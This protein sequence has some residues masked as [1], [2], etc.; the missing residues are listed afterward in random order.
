MF[1]PGISGNPRGRPKGS[2]GGRVEARIHETFELVKASV[3]QELANG[4]AGVQSGNRGSAIP[5]PART[6]QQDAPRDSR[7]DA[8]PSHRQDNDRSNGGGSDRAS[9]RQIKFITDLASR[10]GLSLV[11]L[12]TDIRDAYGVDGLYDLSRKQASSLLD[13]LNARNRKAA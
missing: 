7:R 5:H 12:N 8:L 10:N 6:L 4:H 9:N 11:D 2:V 13:R 3:E 1:Q